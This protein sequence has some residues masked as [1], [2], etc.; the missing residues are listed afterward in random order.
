M[1]MFKKMKKG[2]TIIELIFVIVLISVLSMG[3]FILLNKESSK[4]MTD[5]QINSATKT[6]MTALSEY[7]VKSA[8]AKYNFYNL[9]AANLKP[10]LALK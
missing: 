2:F 1:K 9:N 8:Q 6:L 10:F 4:A 7:K 3:A 5:N